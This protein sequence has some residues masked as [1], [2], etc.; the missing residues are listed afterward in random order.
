MRVSKDTG[1]DNE[2][3]LNFHHVLLI[4]YLQIFTHAVIK[5]VMCIIENRLLTEVRQDTLFNVA[6]AVIRRAHK[7]LEANGLY[8]KLYL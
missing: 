6:Q 1:L 3:Q 8:F 5:K 4:K 2:E 7:C